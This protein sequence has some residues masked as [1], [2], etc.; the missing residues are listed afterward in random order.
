MRRVYI[1]D[2]IDH[3]WLIRMLE[4]PHRRRSFPRADQGVAESRN[5]LTRRQGRAPRGGHTW[6]REHRNDRLRKVFGLLNLKLRGYY[7][8]YGVIG[9]YRRLKQFF[10]ACLRILYKWLNR[11]S[12]HR[13][14]D[15]GEFRAVVARYGVLHPH[16]TQ[17]PSAPVLLS[18]FS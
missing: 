1:P 18:A 6:C 4:L 14:F 10:D 16:I 8:Y 7:N 17:K 13:S 11:R 2:H 12:Q 5:P 15:W 9:N 3:Q